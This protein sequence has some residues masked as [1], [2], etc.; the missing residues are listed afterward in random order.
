MLPKV[1]DPFTQ[2][3]DPG[4][5]PPLTAEG[6]AGEQRELI[7]FTKDYIGFKQ[8]TSRWVSR[9]EAD[10]L[11]GTGHA[12]RVF[13]QDR[14]TPKPAADG[15]KSFGD[16]LQAVVRR[17]TEYL[18]KHYGS[19]FEAP[20]FDRTVSTKAALAEGSGQ[21][22]GYT[23]PPEYSQRIAALIAER[24]IFRPQ[25]LVL[26]AQAATLQ[27]PY[28]DVTTA[29]A[30]GQSPFFGGFKLS[31]TGEAQA[32]TESEPQFKQMELRAWELSGYLTISR[33]LLDDGSGEALETFLVQLVGECSAWTEDY[34]FLQ[35]SGVGQPQGI[36]GAAATLTVSRNT[37]SQVVYSD[38]ATMIS[39]LPPASLEFACWAH[40]PSTIPQL[41]QLKDGSNRAVFLAAGQ[42]PDGRGKWS[43]CGMPAYC[44]EKLPA[45]GT[46]GDLVLFDPRFYAIMERGM[47]ISASE[48]VSFLK[49]QVVI[50][51][52]RRVDGQPRLDKAIALAD[53]S[54]TC[55]PSVVLV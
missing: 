9:K 41:M 14:P 19:V 21:L 46:R 33:P 16:F 36:I 4:S 13:I 54:T 44:T 20:E 45:L 49:N 43:L 34:A 30:A 52:V 55:S 47:L 35:G 28:L 22:G 27:V 42:A 8:G 12:H 32:R 38:V 39:K 40:S 37:S 31:W 10:L 18:G 48:H 5:A 51:V 17:D 24:S 11:A 26:P 23:V 7:Y 3:A 25:A 15:S 1:T 53:G 50:R 29:Q 6:P 2:L